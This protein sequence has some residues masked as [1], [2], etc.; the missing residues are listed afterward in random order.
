MKTSLGE[1][2]CEKSLN[3]GGKVAQKSMPAK[4]PFEDNGYS[5]DLLH[6]TMTL[7]FKSLLL[8]FQVGI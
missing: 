8:K 7:W 1:I 2:T 3:A 6:R 5:S 4:A